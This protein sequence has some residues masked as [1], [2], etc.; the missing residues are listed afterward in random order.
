MF[1]EVAP[2]LRRLTC[3][4]PQDEP[5]YAKG[6][7]RFIVNRVLGL[8]AGGVPGIGNIP[9]GEFWERTTEGVTGGI[10]K[11]AGVRLFLLPCIEPL[12]FFLSLNELRFIDDLLDRLKLFVPS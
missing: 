5:G 6:F 1:I 11:G 9:V 3:L 10:V 8:A 2:I 12:F 7:R 4:R